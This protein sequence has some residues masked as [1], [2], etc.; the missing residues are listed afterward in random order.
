MIVKERN[1]N[2]SVRKDF[3]NLIINDLF[4]KIGI[5]LS[6]KKTAREEISD[7]L[8]ESMSDRVRDYF[9]T[10]VAAN[11]PMSVIL[12]ERLRDSDKFYIFAVRVIPTGAILITFIALLGDDVDPVEL[13]LIY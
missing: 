8:I 3:K 13:Q 6:T 12:P 2:N 9:Y 1:F 7:S 10:L 5:A 4:D 11:T